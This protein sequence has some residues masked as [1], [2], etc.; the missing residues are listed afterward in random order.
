VVRPPRPD[1]DERNPAGIASK[2][3][4]AGLIGKPNPSG[5]I[6]GPIL[7]V[8]QQV[9]RSP[10]MRGGC[11]CL[12]EYLTNLDPSP[13]CEGLREIEEPCGRVRVDLGNGVPLAC[14]RLDRDRDGCSDWTFVGEIE[15]CGP[16]KLVKRNDVLF[17]LVRGCDLTRIRL[18]GWE[19]MHRHEKAIPFKTFAGSFG[20]KQSNG[21]YAASQYWV[22]F[23]R[24]VRERTVRADCFSMTVTVPEDEGGW[25]EVKRVPILGVVLSGGMDVPKDHVTRAELV[26]D[27]GWVRDELRESTKT[28][29]NHQEVC[30]EI[31]IRGDYI[32]DCNGQ[33]VDANAVGLSPYPTGNGTPG[34]TFLSSFLVAARGSSNVSYEDEQSAKGGKS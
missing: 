22:E 16:R 13:D 15:A 28:I 5:V 27:G 4:P 21:T 10:L 11:Q 33:A 31:E 24:P 6:E 8:P 25:R 1:I 30:V 20:V 26:I 17:D 23:S 32:V 29:F 12:C 9:S 34:G 7:E 19:Q 14:V 18:I 3:G 2:R